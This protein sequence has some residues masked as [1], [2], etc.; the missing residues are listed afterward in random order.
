LFIKE[1]VTA[2]TSPI[3]GRHNIAIDIGNLDRFN[4]AM[5]ENATHP[6]GRRLLTRP[7]TPA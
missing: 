7:F 5:D 3:I 4:D 1:A 2:V 6:C